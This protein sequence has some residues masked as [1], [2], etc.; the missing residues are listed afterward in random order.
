MTPVLFLD[1]D[2]VLNGQSNKVEPPLV[3]LLNQIVEQSRC[4]VVVSSAWRIDG[5]ERLQVVLSNA[6]YTGTLRD[7]TPSGGCTEHFDRGWICSEAH[8]GFEILEWL[9]TNYPDGVFPPIVCLDDSSDLHPFLDRHV[10]TRSYVGLEDRHV[11]EALQILSEPMDPFCTGCWAQ[12]DPDTC[13]C[14]DSLKYHGSCL[15]AG[16]S[17]VPMGCNCLRPK[18]PDCAECENK[19]FIQRMWDKTPCYSCVKRY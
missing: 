3:A 11:A 14:G 18:R 7:V 1:F 2:G 15:T 19:R 8:R 5:V 9:R 10:H 12:I 17:F 16:H 4:D 6:G 13:G